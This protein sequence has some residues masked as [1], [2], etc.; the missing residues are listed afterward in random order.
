MGGKRKSKKKIVA[1]RKPKLSTAF[2]CPFC[3]HEMSCI[4]ELYVEVFCS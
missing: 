3:A 1:K 4:V 2:K